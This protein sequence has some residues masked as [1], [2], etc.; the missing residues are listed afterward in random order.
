MTL[1][2]FSKAGYTTFA[3]SIWQ[4]IQN[5]LQH[6]T[7][8]PTVSNCPTLVAFKPNPIRTQLRL[9]CSGSDSTSFSKRSPA[10]GVP[11]DTLKG[12]Q[13]GRGKLGWTSELPHGRP[14]Q[15]A[16][17]RGRPWVPN[18]CSRGQR[19]LACQTWLANWCELY[20]QP[21][22]TLFWIGSVLFYWQTVHVRFILIFFSQ[23]LHASQPQ[24][25]CINISRH[26]IHHRSVSSALVEIRP[27][28]R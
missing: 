28:I 15:K 24:V 11:T 14:F 23:V 18:S 5:N 9:G 17:S 21:S 26:Y 27:P 12:C 6:S 16:Q 20:G 2:Q 10:P 25:R 3:Q 19:S 8:S 13:R 22:T 1:N 7:Q 4:I